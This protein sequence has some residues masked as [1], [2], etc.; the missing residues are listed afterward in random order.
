[1]RDSSL[2]WSRSRI[3][4]FSSWF[5][6]DIGYPKKGCSIKEK[7]WWL[8]FFLISLLFFIKRLNRNYYLKQRRW[9]FWSSCS[10]LVLMFNFGSHVLF[11][12]VI[13]LKIRDGRK[14][15]ASN[16]DALFSSSFG[17]HFPVKFWGVPQ[18]RG[19]RVFFR[20]LKNIR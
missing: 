11:F 15:F 1:M 5:S 4:R 17:S 19:V 8:S 18:E 14:F 2:V 16:L 20:G 6:F 12:L 7:S 13:M 3:K 9:F 10:I